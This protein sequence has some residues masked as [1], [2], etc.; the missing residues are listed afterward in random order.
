MATIECGH[1]PNQLWTVG[2]GSGFGLNNVVL[3]ANRMTD[4]DKKVRGKIRN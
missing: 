1:N 4:R 2:R 3:T